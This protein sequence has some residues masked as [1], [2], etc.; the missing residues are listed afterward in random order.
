VT[1]EPGGG[2]DFAAR[3]IAQGLTAPLGQPVVVDNRGGASGAIAGETVAKGAPDGH[4]L[5]LYGS[6][7]WL[8]PFLRERVPYD[9]LKDLA[10]ISLA[11][12]APNILVVHPSLPVKST[13]ELLALARTRPGALNYGADFLQGQRPRAQRA[14][15]RRSA[16]R[17]CHTRFGRCTYQIAAAAAAGSDQSAALAP[18]AG[19]AD[20]G[21]GG[22]ARL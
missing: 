10:P 20:G 22:T 2:N 5:L 1:S 11:V 8:L 14:H 16:T 21:L 3:V 4:L 7:I 13:Q 15:R 9:P 17:V 12:R 18:A 19:F 6:N